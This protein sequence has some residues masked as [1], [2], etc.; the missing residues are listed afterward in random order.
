[1]FVDCSNEDVAEGPFSLTA[2]IRLFIYLLPAMTRLGERVSS[3]LFLMPPMGRLRERILPTVNE[4]VF[5]TG[6]S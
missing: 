2:A 1:M 5:G 4:F 6:C 3:V